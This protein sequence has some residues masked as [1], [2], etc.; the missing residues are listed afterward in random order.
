M[1]TRFK[2]M[3]VV[4]NQD[5]INMKRLIS[6]FNGKPVLITESGS[7][8]RGTRAPAGGGAGAAAAAADGQVEGAAPGP[9]PGV[10]S[11][12]EG[13][14]NGGGG[15][16]GSGGGSFG[17]DEYLELDIHVRRWNYMARKGLNKLSPKIGLM[18]VS[19][20]FL[21]EGREDS[22]VRVLPRVSIPMDTHSV[23][24]CRGSP[25]MHPAL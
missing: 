11:S 8:V 3:A 4:N 1:R 14:T 18:N 12:G 22:E 16:G 21:I 23:P 6:P 20:A 2:A 10:G 5:V 17:A 24:H 25:A 13:G 19:V 9:S 15:S 7:L